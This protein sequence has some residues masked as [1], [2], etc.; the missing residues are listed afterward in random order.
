[1]HVQTSL[2]VLAALGP[3]LWLARPPLVVSAVPLTEP[4][5]LPRFELPSQVHEVADMARD[6]AGNLVVVGTTYDPGFPTTA[7]AADRS[8][9]SDGDA[10]AIVVATDGSLRYSTCLGGEYTESWPK[11]A[12][13]ADGSLWV[14]TRT[15]WRVDPRWVS[16]CAWDEY[17]TRLW[18][19]TPG[20]SAEQ[21]A[22][23]IGGPEAHVSL[24]DLAAAPDGSVWVLGTA[25]T[26][27]LQTVNA[28]QPVG[29]GESDLIVGHY[30][31]GRTE[32][33]LL[34][35]LGGRSMDE[36]GRLAVAVDGD[37]VVT[38]STSSPDFPVVRPVPGARSGE[39]RDAVLARFDA[40]GRWI[41]YSTPL[42]A[43]EW[44]EQPLV[45]ID[46]L[47]HA[48]VA[49]SARHG[50]FPFAGPLDHPRRDVH[51]LDVDDAGRLAASTSIETGLA[52]IA[53]TDL[54]ARPVFV[55][56]RRDESVV[57]V[58]TWF[59][60]DL[61]AGGVFVALTDR[62]GASLRRPEVILPV[63]A[64]LGGLEAVAADACR[65]WLAWFEKQPPDERVSRH[66]VT[67][68]R[69]GDCDRTGDVPA[70]GRPR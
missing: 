62:F 42:G 26:S 70:H 50:G 44:G 17:H 27:S 35:F 10:F 1:M 4:S 67:S 55:G 46:A 53:A 52:G 24:S 49:C 38:G 25:Y 30:A 19:L 14:G 12:T 2:A 28:W 63:E 29:A 69:V 51:L 59:S 34:T 40:A 48:L 11:V 57:V 20:V 36:A 5:N 65:L 15:C 33:L 8:C 68:L 60:D 54:Y 31:R 9:G 6:A 22:L 39:A 47:G 21:D 3:A 16:G 45:S 18:R 61:L 7:D 37:V 13:A 32:P 64:G 41:D 66:F 23:W 58:G 56:A 43:S